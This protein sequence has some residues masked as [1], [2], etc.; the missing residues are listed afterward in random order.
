MWLTLVAPGGGDVWMDVN[1]EC[2]LLDDFT[3]A[4]RDRRIGDD[5]PAVGDVDA[6]AA[7]TPAPDVTGLVGKRLLSCGMVRCL[8][9]I[10]LTGFS[11]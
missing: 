10:K 4:A 7:A 2:V 9:E 5:E 1:K 11:T 3:S 8:A 6:L